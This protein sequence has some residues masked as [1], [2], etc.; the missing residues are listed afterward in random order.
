QLSALRGQLPVAAPDFPGFGAG[1]AGPDVMTMDAA[2]EAGLKAMDAAGIERAVVCG[3][4][5]GGYVALAFWRNH[6]DRV[7]GLVLADTRSGADDD[8]GKQRR[9][10][11]ADRLKA[12]GNGFLADSPPPLLSATASDALWSQVKDIIRRQ[13]AGSIAAASLG[14]GERPD[15]TG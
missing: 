11:L 7:A 4:S 6:K 15:Y 14:M 3:L 2:A 1:G 8:A 12:E 5:M 10:D 13:P 9:K